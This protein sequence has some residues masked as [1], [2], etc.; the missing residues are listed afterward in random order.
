MTIKVDH[1]SFDNITMRGRATGP[2]GETIKVKMTYAFG[3][4]MA[5]DDTNGCWLRSNEWEW[6]Y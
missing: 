3:P 1:R 2:N 4:I 6:E 5:Y